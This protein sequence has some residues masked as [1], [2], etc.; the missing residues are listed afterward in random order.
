MFG[1]IADLISRTGY[2]GIALLMFFE[3]LFPPIPSELVMPLAGFD[4]ARGE[5]NVVG[6]VA[7][8]TVGS[9]LGAVFWYYVGK[10]VGAERLKGWAGRHGRWLTMRPEDVDEVDSWFDRHCGKAVLIGRLVP[11]IRTLISIP[12][13]IF[14]MSLPRFL[15]FSTLGT[16]LWNTLLTAA[17]YALESRYAAVAEYLNPVTTGIVAIIVGY[18]LYRLATWKSG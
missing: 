13:G 1:W 14:G 11:A 9:V 3:N 8:G 7:A 16:V 5:L 17:G 18:Y 6:V 2:L 12:A 10:L 15:L 4:A